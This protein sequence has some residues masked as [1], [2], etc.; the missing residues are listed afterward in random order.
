MSQFISTYEHLKAM[1]KLEKII[2][3]L[4]TFILIRRC[5]ELYLVN[6]N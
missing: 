5:S 6:K 2:W 3:P 1:Y 4:D